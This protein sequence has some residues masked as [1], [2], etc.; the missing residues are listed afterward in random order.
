MESALRRKVE[1]ENQMTTQQDNTYVPSLQDH[2]AQREQREISRIIWA[3]RDHAWLNEPTRHDVFDVEA[4]VRAAHDYPS[5]D[6]FDAIEIRG[7]A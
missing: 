2:M 1:D 4:V 3:E 6:V 5:E 7:M